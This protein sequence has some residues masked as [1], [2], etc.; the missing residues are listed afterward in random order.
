[1]WHSQDVIPIAEVILPHN[2]SGI[3][4]IGIFELP[5]NKISPYKRLFSGTI[6]FEPRRGNVGGL[7][8][9]LIK[10]R[11]KAMNNFEDD[12]SQKEKNM[13]A[14]MPSRNRKST[15]CKKNTPFHCNCTASEEK[16]CH[17]VSIHT[18]LI[19]VKYISN[20]VALTYQKMK[21]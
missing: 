20:I 14:I 5:P 15:E 11:P 4:W 18:C 17:H 6:G 21:K 7:Y 9:F 10:R 3:T 12:T 13:T 2:V 1:M 8:E 19:F 16:Q